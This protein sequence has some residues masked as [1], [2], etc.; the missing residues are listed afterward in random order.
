MHFI[1]SYLLV[2]QLPPAKC[3]CKQTGMSICP[4]T[5]DGLLE[6]RKAALITGTAHGPCARPELATQPGEK[7]VPAPQPQ[8]WSAT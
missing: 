4:N 5:A 2:F 8:A 3:L 1:V 6:D 7:L